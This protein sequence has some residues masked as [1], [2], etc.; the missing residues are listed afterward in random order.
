MKTRQDTPS[1][2]KRHHG[3]LRANALGFPPLLAQSIALISPTMTAVLII[4][5]AYSDAGRATWLAYAFGTV[6]LLFVVLGLNQFAS[7]SASAGSMYAYT[8][9]GLGPTAGVMS[10]WTLL[11]CYL[12]IGIAG[13][14]GF[15]IFAN[16]FL[17]AIGI[18]ASVPTVVLFAI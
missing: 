10:G 14:S 18:H 7:R 3:G 1:P 2:P 8:G 11:C 5:L 13:L 4:A 9:K 12:F 16:Q 15:S 17:S 6:M